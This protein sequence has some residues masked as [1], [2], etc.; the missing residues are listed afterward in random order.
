MNEAN[1]LVRDVGDADFD[2]EVIERSH[3]VPILVDF[4]AAWCGPCRALTPMLEQAVRELGGKVE[5]VK[6]DTEANPAVAQRYRIM[7][8][9]A[10][11]LLH[12]GTVIGEFVG[13]LSLGQIRQFLRNELPS[14]ADEIVQAALVLLHGEGPDAARGEIERAL[15]L[16]PT[17]AGARLAAVRLALREGDAEALDGHIDALERQDATSDETATALRL[18]EVLGFGRVCDEAGGL[19]ACRARLA[20]QDDLD[21]R[22]AL[23]CCHAVREQYRDALEAFLDVVRRDNRHRDGAARKAM[24][25]LFDLI[26]RRDPLVDE[27]VRQLQIYA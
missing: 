4:W 14:E 10:V 16:D 24:V 15:E 17:H 26:G 6:I 19:Q 3:E 22:Y 23:G 13:A 5:L 18:R 8:I 12:R 21:D 27:Y 20:K 11:K 1:E 25:T 2:V 9:P 7:S